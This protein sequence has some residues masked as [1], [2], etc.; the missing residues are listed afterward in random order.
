MTE[1]AGITNL[2]HDSGFTEWWKVWTLEPVR[3]KSRSCIFWLCELEQLF[4]LSDFSSLICDMKTIKM[5]TSLKSSLGLNRENVAVQCS[6]TVLFTW[7]AL[8]V[9]MTITSPS[10]P[11]IRT[12]CSQLPGWYPF[13]RSSR[14][15]QGS[16]PGSK[17][18]SQRVKSFWIKSHKWLQSVKLHSRPSC[19]PK[20]WV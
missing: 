12:R 13:L 1:L 9:M 16:S 7:A 20:P 19:L 17:D 10:P 5:L 4:N 14:P 2:W 6:I 18:E 15:S 8:Y 11:G 3:I